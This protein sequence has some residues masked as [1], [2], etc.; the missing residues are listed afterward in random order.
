MKT[1]LN[2]RIFYLIIAATCLIAV[3]GAAVYYF[4]SLNWLGIS[5]TM[6]LSAIGLW[7]FARL[8][9]VQKKDTFDV[10]DIAERF[11]VKKNGIDWKDIALTCAWLIPYFFFFI[12]SFLFL[13]NARTDVSLTS[14]WQVVPA[15]FFIFYVLA[16]AYLFW[17]I[18]RQTRFTGALIIAHYF[19]SFSVLW[20]V[21]QIGYGYDPFIHQATVQL[22]DKQGAVFPKTPYYLGQYSLVLIAHKIFFIPIV[23]ADKLLVPLLAALTLPPAIYLFTKRF[24]ITLFSSL[25]SLL[26]L[27]ILPFSIFTLTVPQNLAYLFLL[28]SILFSLFARKREEIILSFL[29]AAAALVTHPVAG[30]PAI[31]F[32]LAMLI[33]RQPGD[34]I[35]FWPKKSITDGEICLDEPH[36]GVLRIKT[37]RLSG[38]R[39]FHFSVRSIGDFILSKNIFYV[40]IALLTAVGLPWLFYLSGKNSIASSGG[41]SA[42]PGLAIPLLAFPRQENI[43]LNF[44]YFFLDNE[45]LFLIIL[46]AAGAYA[47]YRYRKKI[48]EFIILGGFGVSLLF[49]YFITLRLNFSFLISYERNDYAQRIICDTFI[50]LVPLLAVLAAKFI[51]LILQAK[52]FLKYAWLTLLVI[53]I[54]ISLYGSYPR[55]DN[56]FNS[57][58]FSVGADDLAAVSWINQDSSTTPYVVLADQQVSVGALWTFGFSH[59]YKK[60]IYFY[61]I[62]TGGPLYQ[63][64]LQMVYQ[65]PDRATALEAAD[66]TGANTVYFVINKYWTDFDK[67]VEQ[68]KIDS[69]SLQNIDNGQLYIFKYIK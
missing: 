16:T 15:R 30:I 66:L 69:D 41:N 34:Q 31:L 10:N 36:H 5:V 9:F 37:T 29:L 26:C 57:R 24:K 67:I 38:R 7:Y 6:V 43:F 58:S 47:I 19:L 27:L 25:L 48:P 39:H 42:A 68:A 1:T 49:A 46:T 3:S 45:W 21:F 22:I 40:L 65:K 59:Y 2:S 55:I 11:I 61:P 8:L 53:L 12:F 13:F 51:S 60:N 63:I 4:Y 17:L 20:I 14:P 33:N 32:A 44:I 50:F 64:Y 28:L 35:C 56:Y 23:W 62:P 52:P 54:A 18:I